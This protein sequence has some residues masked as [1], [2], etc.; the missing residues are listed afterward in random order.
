LERKYNLKLKTEGEYY[1]CAYDSLVKS[2]HENLQL[3]ERLNGKPFDC[4]HITGGGSQSEF[5][6]RLLA[7]KFK[8][9][10]V[11]GPVEG[12]TVGNIILQARSNGFY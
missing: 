12:A 4:I 7:N 3:F 1:R 10:V 9:N 2:F 6:C 8:I 5:L 11:A